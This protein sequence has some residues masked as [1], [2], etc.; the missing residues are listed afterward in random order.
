M[1]PGDD[2]PVL[3]LR[4]VRSRFD[5]AAKSFDNADFVHEVTRNA[6]IERL[7]PML[8][9][10]SV[11][12][13]LGSATGAS[14]RLLSRLFRRAC[15][16]P[17]D[18][19]RPMLLTARKKQGWF[20]KRGAVQADAAHLPF[21]EQSVDVVFSNLL[22]PWIDDPQ[23]VFL[24]VSRVLRKGGLFSFATLGPDSLRQ[25]RDAWDLLDPGGRHVMRFADMHDIGDGL[26]R[27]GLADP[28]LDVDRLTISYASPASLFRDLTAAGARNSM[29]GREKSL[30]GKQRF[31]DLCEALEGSS[32]DGTIRIDLE[33]VYGHCWGAGGRARTDEVRVSAGQ[34]PVRRR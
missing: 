27:A 6:L 4:D 22:L 7:R 34:I 15:V 16:V 24:E 25:L 20:S 23:R 14:T 26:V 1:P 19:S 21:A 17:V 32:E 3:N 28:V 2:N 12:V 10:A 33:L 31:A 5:R 18:L 13:D 8:V 30:F 11:V 29:S 9:D